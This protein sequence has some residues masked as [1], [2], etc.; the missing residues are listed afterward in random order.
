[1]Y[2]KP[3]ISSE[4]GTGT[5]YINIDRETGIVVP[6]SDPT[7]L[8]QAMDY[9]W[10]NPKQAAAMGK[11]AEARYW[12][13]FTGNQMAQAYMI[14]YKSLMPSVEPEVANVSRIDPNISGLVGKSSSEQET[15]LPRGVKLPEGADSLLSD[16]FRQ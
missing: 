15:S 12:K 10:D 1:M 7:A 3:L 16:Q 2:G 4:I 11:N 6:P 9:L 14:L 8:R 13:L 5:T